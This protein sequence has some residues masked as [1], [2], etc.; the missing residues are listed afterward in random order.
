[1]QLLTATLA[2]LQPRLASQVDAAWHDLMLH[3][4]LYLGLCLVLHGELLDH[5]S[6]G[7]RDGDAARAQRRAAT[8]KAYAAILGTRPPARRAAPA[9]TAGPSAGPS[10]GPVGVAGTR[11]VTIET[12]TGK[13]H[14]LAIT[15]NTCVLQLM[16]D[17]KEKT[18]APIDQQRLIYKGTQFG[19][20][21]GL[22][23]QHVCEQEEEEEGSDSEGRAAKR[24]REEPEPEPPRSSFA[25]AEESL[26]RRVLDICA[27]AGNGEPVLHLVLKMRGC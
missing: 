25:A 13:R 21:E 10:A 5:S 18:G 1:M 27:D 7:A 26:M 9:A 8:L 14:R 19:N 23:W 2:P 20:T 22:A 4:K 24:A 17:I 15:P 3:P 11:M 6:G 16:L 12:L